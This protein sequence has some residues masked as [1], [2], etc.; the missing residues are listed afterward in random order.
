MPA[1]LLFS[2][3]MLRPLRREP[4][5]TALTVLAIALGVAVVLAID[6]A[7]DAAA[8]SFRSSVETLAGDA[9]F[10]V[11]APGGLP[12]SVAATLATMPYALNLR[13][14]I[15][16]SA[17]IIQTGHV[18]PLIGVDMVADASSN[19]SGAPQDLGNL[20]TTPQVWIGRDFPHPAS[21]TL[22]LR[23]N[24]RVVSLAIRGRLK[25]NTG[26][27]AVIDL[28]LADRL[29]HRNG[30][31]DRILIRIPKGETNLDAWENR[32]RSA[33][34]SGIA[35]ERGGARTRENRK[36]LE[37][38]RWNLRVLSYIALLVGAFLIYN[39]ISVSVVRRRAEVGIL[40][41]LGAGRAAIAAAFL[42]ESAAFGLTGSLLGILLGRLLALG[43]VSLVAA[44]VESLYVSSTPAPI[45]LTLPAALAALVLG[46]A[47]SVLSGLSPAL[48]AS[49]V[50]PTEAMAR[51][52]VDYQSRVHKSRDLVLA[53]L[54]AIAA[55]LASRMPPVEGKPL[56]GYLAA[57][58]LVAACSL[59]I[60]F[61]TAS[62]ANLSGAPLR[63][64]LG[65][66][67]FLAGRGLAASLRRTSVLTA[68]L[69]VAVAMMAAVGIMV[70]SFRETVSLWMEN[71]LKADLYLRPAGPESA[72]R[73]PVMAASVPGK[74]EQLPEV[75]AVNRFRAY[76]ISYGGLPATLASTDTALEHRF[77]R[78][79]FLGGV[80]REAIF[81]D[82]PVGNYAVVSEPF[83]N[84]HHVEAGSTLT[85]SLGG[86]PVPLR[87]LGVYYDYASE[88][89]YVLLDRHV[90]LRYLPD[91]AP[92]NVAVYLKPGVP[93]DEG[94]A[95]VERAIGSHSVLVIANRSLRDQ[96]MRIFDR[97]FAI[98]YALE[99]VAILVAV[100]GMAGALLALIID[101][102]RELGLLRFL[103][104]SAPQIRRLILFEAGLLGLLAN[105]IGLALG[106]LLSL[107][108]IYV[109]NKQ[110]F[111]WTIQFHWPVAVL[112]GSL[113][114]VFAAAVLSGLYPARVAM[115]LN[116]IEVVHEE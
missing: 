103:G 94:R 96:A 109:I 69:A 112:L 49:N 3:L 11:T 102:R 68:A 89:G 67:A 64:L 30:A 42:A 17:E 87:I 58:L 2:R 54:L 52:R 61:L 41:A 1:A 116:P 106:V 84:K 26:E 66:E 6:L 59:A 14:R 32:L 92:S 51:G 33:L 95:A 48:E 77:G 47:V 5:R 93:L 108:L 37:A 45:S 38:F 19:V 105:L 28:A 21:G 73:H 82:L 85:L 40:R 60:P 56:F 107:I 76:A 25:G 39:T 72:D 79:K 70:G 115:R 104:S 4:A 18:V 13:P 34:P 62:L 86:H 31:L 63:R 113:T 81:H 90:L 98:T 99:A 9:D 23:V 44:T 97:T 36:M 16:D 55:L 78:V 46:T 101:R 100:M 91:P 80:N 7:G 27:A 114:T 71:Q 22:D 65:V 74:I 88:R 83:A 50:P 15:E 29:L 110:S 10:E 75:L 57:L 43:A 111:G 12:A 35:L 8:G 53:A 24:D 20:S